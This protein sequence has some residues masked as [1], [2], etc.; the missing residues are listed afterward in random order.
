MFLHYMFEI[1]IAIQNMHLMD[2]SYM[3]N[4]NVESNMQKL[5]WIKQEREHPQKHL[6]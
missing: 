1:I 4:K 6:V 3:S 2:I 5:N